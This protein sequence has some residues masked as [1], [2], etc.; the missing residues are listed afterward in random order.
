MQLTRSQT[1]PC[2]FC[3][4]IGNAKQPL[5]NVST[6]SAGESLN[7]AINQSENDVLRVKLSTAVDATD[8]HAIDIKYHK[9]CWLRNVT[10]VIKK[11][12][13]SDNSSSD[14][15]SEPAARI[16]FLATTQ[17]ALREEEILT[18]SEL[19]NTFEELL[20]AFIRAVQCQ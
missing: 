11:A 12:S 4:E 14:L 10:N 2:F 19:Q 16:E 15:V 5:H 8:A 18:M 3:E 1:S 7:K 13:F 6:F 9:N 17:T 20:R